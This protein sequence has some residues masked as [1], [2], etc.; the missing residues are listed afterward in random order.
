MEIYQQ[1]VNL[2]QQSNK[3]VI[4]AHKSPD[5]DSIGSSLG[6]FRFINK[7]NKNVTI[8]HPD[9][10]PTFFN[11]LGD[12]QD[13]IVFEENET[14]VKDAIAAADLLI[15]LDYNDYSR[16]GKD[17]QVVLEQY[18]GKVIMIDHHLNPSPIADLLLSKTEVCSTAQLIY[19]VISQSDKKSLLDTHIV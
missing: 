3:I 13:I 12:V 6:L 8:C 18:T 5:G 19:D 4:T 17:M 9:K 10:A 14:V 7:L 15:C 1:I 11:W 2:I 16:V